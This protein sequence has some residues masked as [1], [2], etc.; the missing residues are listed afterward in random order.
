MRTVRV[1]VG[2]MEVEVGTMG[3]E[4]GTVEWRCGWG[5]GWRAE[6]MKPGVGLTRLDCRRQR[7][8]IQPK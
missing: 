7:A 6:L 4:V 1:E 5:L 2:T 3:V 8:Q